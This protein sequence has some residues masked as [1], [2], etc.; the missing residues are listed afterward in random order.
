MNYLFDDLIAVRKHMKNLF[1]SFIEFLRHSKKTVL[2]ILIVAATTLIFSTMIS[3]WLSS[4]DNYLIPSLGTIHTTGVNAYGGNIT[5][6]DGNQSI[7]W[8]TIYPGTFTNR[9]FYVQS[10]SNIE[11]TLN[12]TAANWTFRDSEGNNVTGSLP[13]KPADAMNVTWNYTGALVSPGKKIYVTLTLWASND[14]R[15]I[16]YLIDKRVE[17]FSFDMHIYA[18]E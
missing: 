10:Q 1:N 2:L 5:L 6:K 11:T 9:S 7:D 12:L 3:I 17:E 14:I 18:K 4:F 8:G 16:N 13:M 15:F